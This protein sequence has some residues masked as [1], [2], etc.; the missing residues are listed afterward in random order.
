[1][2][3]LIGLVVVVGS[4]LGGYMPHGDILA[5]RTMAPDGAKVGEG[6]PPTVVV[7]IGPPPADAAEAAPSEE[8]IEDLIAER[9]QAACDEAQLQLDVAPEGN[10]E[11]SA[12]KENLIIDMTPDG[13]RIQLVDKEGGSLFPSGS[14]T[15]PQRTRA[16]LDQISKVIAELPNNISISG[17]TDA[18]PFGAGAGYTNWELSADRANASRRAMLDGGIPGDRISEVVGKADISPLTPEDPFLPENRRIS[19]VLLRNSPVL[20]PDM[21]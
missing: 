6:Q 14:A 13:M 21:R 7:E 9:E 4:V 10:P 2:I 15:M 17:H 12:L 16:L 5:G 3:F 18:Q 8:D 20:P 11:I 19:I 1:M